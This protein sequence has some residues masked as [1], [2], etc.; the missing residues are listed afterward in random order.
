M[1]DFDY[2]ENNKTAERFVKFQLLPKHY[3][4]TFRNVANGKVSRVNTFYIMIIIKT[5][6]SMMFRCSFSRYYHCFR[7]TRQV[8]FFDLSFF[9]RRRLSGI[10]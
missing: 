8:E 1:V 10:P 5:Y 4:A 9:H 2:A 6:C 7:E 3:G